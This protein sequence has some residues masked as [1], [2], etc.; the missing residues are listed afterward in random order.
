[1][2]YT[3]LRVT[4]DEKGGVYKAPVSHHLFLED[5]VE[6]L[7]R[8]ESFVGRGS[9]FCSVSHFVVDEDGEPVSLDGVPF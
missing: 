8:H 4:S 3:V 6:A 2:A 7:D 9:V 1:M 5:A